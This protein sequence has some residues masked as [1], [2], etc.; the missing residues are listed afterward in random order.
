M[1]EAIV[2]AGTVRKAVWT[3]YGWLVQFEDETGR[4]AHEVLLDHEPAA[5]DFLPGERYSLSL[6]RV[7]AGESPIVE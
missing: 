1:D 3:R 6:S 4:P 7:P 2:L 5:E